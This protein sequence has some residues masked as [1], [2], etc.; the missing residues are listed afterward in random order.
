MASASTGIRPAP[1]FVRIADR[2]I[3]TNEVLWVREERILDL[4]RDEDP[5]GVRIAF[6]RQGSV[7]I[8]GM[9]LDGVAALLNGDPF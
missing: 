8:E 1:K 3:N 4:G 5:R 2:V 7:L 6:I 9:T